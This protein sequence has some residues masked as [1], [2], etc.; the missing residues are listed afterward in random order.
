MS[1]RYVVRGDEILQDHVHRGITS[2]LGVTGGSVF[3]ERGFIDFKA[4][5]LDYFLRLESVLTAN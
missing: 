5:T 3:D 2:T 1:D 4:G